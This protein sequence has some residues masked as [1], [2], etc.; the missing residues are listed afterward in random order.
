MRPVYSTLDEW[1]IQCMLRRY[2]LECEYWV[3][4]S[5]HGPIKSTFETLLLYC[6]ATMSP[7][8]HIGAMWTVE[9]PCFVAH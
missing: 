7:R 2:F 5:K 8:V 4:F 1:T 6:G 9:P 3:E